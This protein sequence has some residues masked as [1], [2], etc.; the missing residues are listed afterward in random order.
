[1]L[2]TDPALSS[3]RASVKRA[4]DYRTLRTKTVGRNNGHQ[5]QTAAITGEIRWPPT[6]RFSWPPTENRLSPRLAL[7]RQL[8]ALPP[9]VRE[10]LKLRVEDDL[11]Y[12]EIAGR[13]AI[14]PN[15]A[16]LRV[17]RGLRRLA[18]TVPKE[19]S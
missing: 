19:D 12:D 16:R 4:P 18:C 9:G 14:Q 6:G 11:D 15:A 2:F 13:L 3:N 1:M 10:A 8:A 7:K 17:S 5:P